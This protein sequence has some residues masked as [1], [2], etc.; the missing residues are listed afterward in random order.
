[1]S[2]IIK[3]FSGEYRFLSNFYPCDITY[4]GISYN[5]TENAYQAQKTDDILIQKFIATVTP[6]KSKS[7]GSELSLSDDWDTRKIKV[8]Y[9]INKLKYNIPELKE[10]LLSTGNMLIIEGNFWND[11][12]WGVCLKTNKGENILGELLM[13][14]RTEI[15]LENKK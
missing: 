3:K 5:S 8:M 12:T 2:N 9:D 6:A 7:I 1:M 14:I 13:Q 11:R 10:L 15:L 4:N